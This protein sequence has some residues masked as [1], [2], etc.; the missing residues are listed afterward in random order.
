M[1]IPNIFGSV[2]LTSKLSLDDLSKLISNKFFMGNE[3]IGLEKRIYDEVPA[4]M[5]NGN[6]IGLN[7]VLSGG[8]LYD[9]T[10]NI[11]GNY[12]PK[13]FKSSRIQLDVYLYFLFKDGLQEYDNIQ[14]IK[15]KSLNDESI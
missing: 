1:I 9:F 7:V 11:L 15:P 5:L 10:I 13:G 8:G 14:V 6:F 2:T 3:F 4:V 12:K